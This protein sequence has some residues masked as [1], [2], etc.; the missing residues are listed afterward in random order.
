MLVSLVLDLFFFYENFYII[1]ELGL[2]NTRKWLNYYN[3]HLPNYK[4]ELR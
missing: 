3:N 1:G 2:C 4:L